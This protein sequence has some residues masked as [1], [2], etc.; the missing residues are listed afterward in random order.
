MD[1]ES[2]G[3]FP[4]L[5][6]WL[7]GPRIKR[8]REQIGQAH[9]LSYL[10][11]I[12]QSIAVV[13]VFGHAEVELLFN[14]TLTLPIRAMALGS[15]FLLVVTVLG[16]DLALVETMM[17]IPALRR[18]RQAGALFEHRVY[19][20]FVLLVEGVT[21]G[22]VIY[23]LD[24]N[25]QALI[26]GR[27]LVPT[28]GLLFLALVVMRV[29]LISWSVVQL[30]IVR[31]K[32]PVLLS[33]LMTTGKEIIGGHLESQ[34]KTL[35]VQ[36]IEPHA[37]MS[38]YSEMSRPPRPIAG[39]LNGLTG[40]WIVRRALAQESEEER[41]A[42]NVITALERIHVSQPDTAPAPTPQPA[43]PLPRPSDEPLPA[44]SSAALARS[45]HELRRAALA[46]QMDT[47]LQEYDLPPDDEDDWARY[48]PPADDR[49]WDEK[50][51]TRIGGHPTS[52]RS[53]RN[54]R[55]SFSNH[56]SAKNGSSAARIS[57]RFSEM[58]VDTPMS[59]SA[60][61]DDTP[62]AKRVM[63][64]L[65]KHPGATLNEVVGKTKV[66]KPTARV[67]YRV[68]VERNRPLAAAPFTEEMPVVLPERQGQSEKLAE[69]V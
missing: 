57:P 53:G 51:L 38:V 49:A 9:W 48:A 18:N 55:A 5:G 40:G 11:I 64:Y 35:N 19:Q 22:V 46:R 20:L 1:H 21:Y 23:A 63:N 41:Q 47:D 65:D 25:P 13:L 36:H 3:F 7:F 17:R 52:P 28:D 59:K 69:R 27:S 2:G 6:A 68:W 4:K 24:S 37:L 14:A 66:S 30:I 33:T 15:L 50:P 56:A 29:L 32:L 43:P 61:K 58:V 8:L 10:L 26:Q 44:A 67:H 34:L 60:R 16:A 45:N 62:E 39:V 31:E 42:A 12:S 54:G